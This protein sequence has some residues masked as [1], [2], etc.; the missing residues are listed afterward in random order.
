MV[1]FSNE[2]ICFVEHTQLKHTHFHPSHDTTPSKDDDVAASKI[3]EAGKLM[4]IQLV[5]FIIIGNG[6]FSYAEEK[7]I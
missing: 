6:Y 1:A 5:D 4:K 3:S 7:R 2:Y